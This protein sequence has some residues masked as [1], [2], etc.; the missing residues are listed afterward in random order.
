[1]KINY[2][3][4]KGKKVIHNQTEYINGMTFKRAKIRTINKNP[5]TK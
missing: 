5:I 4:S 3:K 2:I 1:M